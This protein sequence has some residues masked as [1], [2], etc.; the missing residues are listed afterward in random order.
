MLIESTLIE[1]Q[2]S[3][4]DD[5]SCSTC[6]ANCCRLEVMLITDTGVPDRYVGLEKGTDLFLTEPR[7]ARLFPPKEMSMSPRSRQLPRIGCT[8]WL[9][10]S[11]EI[12]E[13]LIANGKGS[14]LKARKGYFLVFLLALCFPAFV[15]AQTTKLCQ[16]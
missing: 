8:V 12:S 2:S 5:V 6:K 13:V 10:L 9:S 14:D 1:T 11:R 16:T 15:I 7:A 3:P 4:D